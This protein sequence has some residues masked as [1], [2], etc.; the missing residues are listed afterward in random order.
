MVPLTIITPAT[1]PIFF[2]IFLLKNSALS[3]GVSVGGEEGEGGDP[4]DV[5]D[6]ANPSGIEWCEGTGPPDIGSSEG[7]GPSNAEEY[8]D[9]DP[10]DPPDADKYGV[11]S[12]DIDSSENHGFLYRH[13][14]ESVD[15]DD[16]WCEG[17][18]L[19]DGEKVSV[20][21]V[22]RSD[23]VSCGDGGIS[24]GPELERWGD[25]DSYNDGGGFGLRRGGLSNNHE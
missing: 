11:E 7:A 14:R 6:G 8:E 9:G 4:S 13:E 12:V 19:S 22:A 16:G 5:K 3:G 18:S 15:N 23:S 21:A 10:P 20:V 25:A 1:I 17:V 2:I 24:D